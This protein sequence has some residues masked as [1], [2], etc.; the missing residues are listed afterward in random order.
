MII[1][2]MALSLFPEH[3]FLALMEQEIKKDYDLMISEHGPPPLQTHSYRLV[4]KNN[5]TP[6]KQRWYL[7]PGFQRRC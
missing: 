3:E 5:T 4:I 1:Y 6:A 2:K 7:I